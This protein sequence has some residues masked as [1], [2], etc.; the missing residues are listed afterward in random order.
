MQLS[1]MLNLNDSDNAQPDV[2]ADYLR[3]VAS[4]IQAGYGDG[5]VRDVNGNTIGRF[6]IIDEPSLEHAC[7]MADAMAGNK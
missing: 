6:E 5:N 7:R 4:R 3:T 1:V 2:V